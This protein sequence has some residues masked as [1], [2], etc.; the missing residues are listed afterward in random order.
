MRYRQ[1]FWDE[2]IEAPN[3]TGKTAIR[4][5]ADINAKLAEIGEKY[6]NL[7]PYDTWAITTGIPYAMYNPATGKADYTE[8]GVKIVLPKGPGAN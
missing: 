6:K 7:G 1:K 8:K 3:E 4:S 2:V 5:K